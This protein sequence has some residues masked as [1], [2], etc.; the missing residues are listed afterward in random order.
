MSVKQD[1]SNWKQR[2]NVSHRLYADVKKKN[3]VFKKYYQGEQWEGFDTSFLDGFIDLVVDNVVFSNIRAIV[4]RIN[5]K[6]PRIFISPKKK[7]YRGEGGKIFDTVSAAMMKEILLNYYYKEL[8]II[9]ETR[10]CLYDALL[11]HWGI[12]ELG[13]TL[14]TEKI[15]DKKLLIVDELI[16]SESPFVKRRS[17]DDFRTDVEGTDH[18]LSDRRW[19]AL[20]WI[21]E[22]QDIK[23]DDSFENK[24]N[25]KTSTKKNKIFKNSRHSFK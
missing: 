25:L 24:A 1:L 16:K 22:L 20:K 4:P 14:K 18:L 6:N 5:F 19:I 12:M 9:R 15:K 8:Q 2:L 3:D 17:P 7:P 23:D 13:F 11:G 10:R 21:K